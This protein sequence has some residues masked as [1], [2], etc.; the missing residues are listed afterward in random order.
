MENGWVSSYH[1][2]S[3]I[4]RYHMCLYYHLQ[5][6]DKTTEI[7]RFKLLNEWLSE[8]TRC[9]ADLRSHGSWCVR[10]RHAW[11]NLVTMH[12]PTFKDCCVCLGFHAHNS[13]TTQ[14]WES[15]FKP[16]VTD[17]K[18]GRPFPR[19]PANHPEPCCPGPPEYHSAFER[20]AIPSRVN[21]SSLLKPSWEHCR[22]HLAFCDQLCHIIK[23]A[24][25]RSV[26][27]TRS[28]TQLNAL[29]VVG[30]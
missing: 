2:V 3:V 22:A 28:W 16:R 14:G 7:Q 25:H 6:T 20:W 4:S 5:I 15:F 1:W 30:T 17:S 12:P 21:S 27:P 8:W 9:W 29:Q 18:L 23:H 10:G 11:P 26:F 24:V 13:A 19:N